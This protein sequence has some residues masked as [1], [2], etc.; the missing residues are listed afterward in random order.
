MYQPG[1]R[2]GMWM[3]YEFLHYPDIKEATVTVVAVDGNLVTLETSSS[4]YDGGTIKETLTINVGSGGKTTLVPTESADGWTSIQGDN[5]VEVV[6]DHLDI[7]M[8]PE[9]GYAEVAF[10]FA[11]PLDISQISYF[12]YFISI[13]DITA[14]E[15]YTMWMTDANGKSKFFPIQ[16]DVDDPRK[17]KYTVWDKK[18]WFNFDTIPQDEL[19]RVQIKSISLIYDGDS[20]RTVKLRNFETDQPLDHGFGNFK[21]FVVASSLVMGDP[22]YPDVSFVVNEELP[23]DAQS[24]PIILQNTYRD[25]IVAFTDCDGGSCSS[26]YTYDKETGILTRYWSATSGIQIQL[27]DQKNVWSA[28]NPGILAV[29]VMHEGWINYVLPNFWYIVGAISIYVVGYVGTTLYDKWKRGTLSLGMMKQW[30]PF[31]VILLIIF[32]L[33][34]TI[35]RVGI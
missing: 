33:G 2:P 12:Y 5:V 18:E 26:A 11:E 15:K 35:R 29:A 27:V 14:G 20:A 8:N 30:W 21:Y 24:D 16:F 22:I 17:S 23:N 28:A 6:D 25:F 34:E 19:D 9:D 32:L 13:T 4:F 3:T 31:L 1:V 7:T 10:T